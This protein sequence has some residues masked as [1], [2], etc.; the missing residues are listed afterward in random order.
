[1]QLKKNRTSSPPIKAEY[2][3]IAQ[4]KT[5]YFG[6]LPS[7]RAIKLLAWFN[8]YE[9][10][11]YSEIPNSS[12][13]QLLQFLQQF[14]GSE[15][16]INLFHFGIGCRRL[17]DIQFVQFLH[18]LPRMKK[19]CA[20]NTHYKN[21]KNY[22]KSFMQLKKNTKLLVARSLFLISLIQTKTPPCGGFCRT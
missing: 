3:V 8:F 7:A 15:A 16:K 20:K 2:P 19:Q 22:N 14:K 6:Q 1:M 4:G 21:D 10:K 5:F 17:K 9:T 12:K 11:N 18:I 13:L